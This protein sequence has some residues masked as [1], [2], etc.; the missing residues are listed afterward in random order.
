MLQS[1]VILPLAKARNRPLQVL[2]LGA[3]N[4]WLAYQLTRQGHRVIGV[5]LLTNMVDGLGAHINYDASFVPVQAEFDRL[6][7][8]AQEIDVVIYNGALHYSTGYHV[9]L[10]EGQRVLRRDGLLVVMDSPIYKDSASGATMVRERQTRFAGRYNFT[11]QSL[12]SENYLTFDRLAELA[13]RL[14]LEW[15]YL[16]P[17]YGLRWKSRRWL[18]R[19]RSG[20][21]PATFLVVAGR[22]L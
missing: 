22:R 10:E 1:G 2:D 17:G 4:G 13:T 6:P 5:D 14:G 7:V 21:E 20:R 9:T 18:A 3:G 19:L 11:D 16:W 15:T 12:P 8:D